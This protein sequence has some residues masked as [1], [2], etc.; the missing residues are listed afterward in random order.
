VVFATLLVSATTMAM[1]IRERTREVAVLKTL[2]FT[3]QSILRLYIGEAVMVALA[4]G[5]LGCLL[6][7]LLVT[8]LAHAP[9]V[10]LY[11]GG[12]TVTP[13]TLLLAI[14]VAGMVGLLSAIVPAYH[15]AK[16]DIVEGLRYI[17]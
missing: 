17:G 14:F 5:A 8:G 9:G 1:S 2:G 4:G 10:G 12:V 7:A 15:A 16:L 13:A 3:R 6:A 11:F